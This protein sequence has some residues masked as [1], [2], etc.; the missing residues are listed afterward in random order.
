MKHALEHPEDWSYE[1]VKTIISN[2]PDKQTKAMACLAYLTGARVSELTQITKENIFI[3]DGYLK[4]RCV[5][6]KKRKEK[7]PTRKVGARL[8]EHWLVEPILLYLDEL[9][10]NTLFPFHRITIY[11]R[12]LKATGFN[13][14][15]FRKLRATHLRKEHNFDSY[16]LKKFFR[17]SS[18][19]PSESYVGVDDRDILY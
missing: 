16:Q 9:Q 7:I 13:P 19:T 1:Q 6:L 18:V 14:H 17:W 10:S 8:D 12:L 2:I 4:V 5:V 3:E 11:T 15:G